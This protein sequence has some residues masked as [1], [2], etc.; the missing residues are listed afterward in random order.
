[1]SQPLFKKRKIA[2]ADVLK[3][4]TFDNDVTCA[5]YDKSCRKKKKK[6]NKKKKKKRKHMHCKSLLSRVSNKQK[7]VDDELDTSNGDPRYEAAD[8]DN[9]CSNDELPPGLSVQ[10]VFNL[11]N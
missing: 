8:N 7:K 9:E 11:I 1:M 5:E 3:V 6:T 4:C 2:P 10:D